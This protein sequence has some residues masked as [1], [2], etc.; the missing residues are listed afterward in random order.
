M[1]MTRETLCQTYER[2]TPE[3]KRKAIEQ[4]IQERLLKVQHGEVVSVE[5]LIHLAQK[6]NLTDRQKLVA[7]LLDT[8]NQEVNSRLECK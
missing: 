7:A 5:K 8:A 1:G 3:E 4:S 6:L 2:C